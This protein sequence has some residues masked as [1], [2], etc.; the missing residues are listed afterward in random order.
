MKRATLSLLVLACIANL[1]Q[2]EVEPV[3]IRV[4]EPKGWTGQKIPFF[5]DLK[6]K[7]TFD[8]S[9]SFSLPEVPQTVIIKVGSPVVSSEQ[10]EGDTWF[11]QT[12]E[13]ALFS[14]H[15]GTVTLPAFEARFASR[16]GF[17]GPATD[18]KENVPETHFEIQR[19]PG[20]EQL[21]FLVTASS[22]EIR[23]TWSPQPGPAKVGDVFKRTISQTADQMTGIALAPPPQS[24]P[25]GVKVYVGD[26]QV[27]D[28]T[29]RGAFTGHRTDTITYVPQQPGPHTLPAVT[30]VW[31]NPET[32]ELRSKTLP[33]VTF[34]VAAPPAPPAAPVRRTA[35]A[36]WLGAI[37]VVGGLLIWQRNNLAQAFQRYRRWLNPPEHVAS[38]H[39]LNACR[40]NDAAAAS[41]AWNVWLNLRSPEFE[42]IAPL[43]AA[44]LD[45]ESRLYG[46][47]SDPWRGNAMA[48]A[49]REQLAVLRSQR[50]RNG[51]S[52]LPQLNPTL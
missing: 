29:E 1:G 30:Y 52:D 32:E 48:D 13:F 9:A 44:A 12:H 15:S 23:E 17:T 5:L 39:L 6:A 31:W 24:V 2:A 25:D 11:V 8:G 26:P 41:R 10:I 3:S 18:R 27:A 35:W 46:T 47:T 45:L 50:P 20:S 40:H 51:K 28:N 37:V 49:V 4:P 34:E 16:D 43:R 19:P 38:R 21:G 33:T 7:G 42:P 22:I 36:W 14:Q